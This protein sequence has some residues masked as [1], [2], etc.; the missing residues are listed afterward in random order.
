[1]YLLYDIIGLP[2]VTGI[3][4]L[5]LTLPLNVL[6]FRA[7]GRA[8]R[9]TID[10]TD[11]R[12]KLINEMVAGIRTIKSYAWEV[13]FVKNL[14]RTRRRELKSIRVHAY[15]FSFGINLIFYQMPFVLMMAV[16]SVYYF[17]GGI[18]EP[19]K[20]FASLQLFNL[21]LQ[22]M[23]QLPNGINQLA[24]AIIAMRRIQKY[25]DLDELGP[26]DD[27]V[28][29]LSDAQTSGDAKE[30][31]VHMRECIFTWNKV[32]GEQKEGSKVETERSNRNAIITTPVGAPVLRDI[33][34]VLRRGETVAVFGSTGSG[35]SSLLLS[36]LGELEKVIGATRTTGTVALSPQDPWIEHGSI[37]ENILFG[38]EYD[39]RW[40]KQIVRACALLPEFK[41]LPD[42]DLTVVGERGFNLSGGQIAR[43]SLA[44]ALYRNP[45]ILLLD[46]PLGSVD[47]HIGTYLLE[48]A[49]LSSLT[50]NML[51]VM[52]TNKVDI[53][54]R[55]DRVLVI[56]DGRIIGNGGYDYLV[57]K[58]VDFPGVQQDSK[59]GVFAPTVSNAFPELVARSSL[60]RSRLRGAR[61][62]SRFE[63]MS[64]PP[65]SVYSA[66][67]S[68]RF[69]QGGPQ[70]FD[71][72][73]DEES[74]AEGDEYEAA[75]DLYKKEDKKGGNVGFDVYLY[76][77]KSIGYLWSFFM[78]F[79]NMAYLVAP[80]AHQYA[81]TFW[82][83]EV[84]CGIIELSG[85]NSSLAGTL[86]CS[87]LFGEDFWW[88]VTFG[89]F[90]TGV[91]LCTI[92][93]ILFAEGRLRCVTRLHER[94]VNSVVAAPISFYDRTPVGR[95]LNRFLKDMNTIDVQLSITLMLTNVVVMTIL[96]SFIGIALGTRGLF[97]A[98]LVP[99][100]FV[101]YKIYMLAR[102]GAI[103]LQRI[104]ATTR[105]PIYS[106][107]AELLH[108]VGTVRAF[109]Q[110]ERF[111]DGNE[112]A[113]RRNVLP[114]F[115]VRI[116]LPS[117]LMISLSFLGV[118][119][120]AG[121]ALII[122]LTQS[123][124]FLSAGEAGLA[125]TFSL[126]LTQNLSQIGTFLTPCLTHI[127]YSNRV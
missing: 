100:F 49:I 48:N 89:I 38:S 82:T 59:R 111:K 50:K 73:I 46:Q 61:T 12:I 34:L 107:F 127:I 41:Q 104:E 124:N 11:E 58:G 35:K 27:D 115:Y 102:H 67:G 74:Y 32:E 72:Y 106:R 108:G 113:M 90:C 68:V 62:S 22:I 7:I 123:V 105:S 91:V 95:V 122:V 8:F 25:L 71:S 110:A 66:R 96:T 51:I 45:S 99:V 47:A 75:N 65:E 114:L 88:F 26:N 10:V 19:G 1:M 120:S 103:Q 119:I 70:N 53:L 23:V 83:N 24:L 55:F 4:V 77:L 116:I 16:M 9:R 42:G 17:T 84:V 3:V 64:Y 79:F 21:L 63:A 98:V 43:I 6:L 39:L 94:L 28:F 85:E 92:A 93:S 60:L 44:R 13:P 40:Y 14:R 87:V 121:V 36:M 118:L 126:S 18:M 29:D 33:D 97:L 80:L 56:K 125:L 76:Y 69:I 31:L 109:N 57:R 101:Y 15:L 117:W 54:G 5:L 2:M 52:V 81:L 37:R 20:V 86:D 78:V 30:V 112:E